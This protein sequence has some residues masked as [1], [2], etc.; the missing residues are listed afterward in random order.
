MKYYL[1]K[2]AK[3]EQHCSQLLESFDYIYEARTVIERRLPSW[4]DVMYL[5][6]EAYEGKDWTNFIKTMGVSYRIADGQN[7]LEIKFDVDALKSQIENDPARFNYDR[8][9]RDLIDKSLTKPNQYPIIKELDFEEYERFVAEELVT[10]EQSEDFSTEIEE[11]T[12]KVINEKWSYHP[13]YFKYD[14]ENTIRHDNLTARQCLGLVR[15]DGRLLGMTSF[16][17]NTITHK[18]EF[19]ADRHVWFIDKDDTKSLIDKTSLLGNF[20]SNKTE[21]YLKNFKEE[22]LAKF[23]CDVQAFQQA[24]P[25]RVL[26][27]V[28][29]VY[30]W[31]DTE[32]DR[33]QEEILLNV[34]D[35]E[36]LSKESATRELLRAL[37]IKKISPLL[38][39]YGYLEFDD[40]SI[41]NNLDVRVKVTDGKKIWEARSNATLDY[42]TLEDL[43]Q[44]IR[45]VTK[46]RDLKVIGNVN[47]VE[48]FEDFNIGFQRDF[49]QFMQNKNWLDQGRNP[50]Q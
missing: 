35:V 38:K 48:E 18:P 27:N 40:W 36:S 16:S 41:W 39:D 14:D 43:L 7:V 9:L 8:G 1:Y 12:L 4:V 45:V 2:D 31:E 32:F 28:K 50:N 26:P 22:I 5:A 24:L 19:D 23:D 44:T 25:I 13:T 6:F 11:A 47:D 34:N 42:G 3:G 49:D 33:E 10:F 30:S 46:L 21:E 37:I 29:A 15:P 20:L 17:I